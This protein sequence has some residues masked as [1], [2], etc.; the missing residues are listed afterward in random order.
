MPFAGS[1]VVGFRAS[2]FGYRVQ[3]VLLAAAAKSQCICINRVYG[4][5]IHSID[6]DPYSVPGSPRL[7]QEPLCATSQPFPPNA[8]T[9]MPGAPANT[10]HASR[11]RPCQRL[12]FRGQRS[13]PCTQSRPP[14]GPETFRE[15]ARPAPTRQSI[16][17]TLWI[18]A[19]SSSTSGAVKSGGPVFAYARS[20]SSEDAER[21]FG[22]KA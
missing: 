6:L 17:H 12:L 22:F 21:L 1:T 8:K 11:I 10:L 7:L 13:T 2:G 9:T 4:E 19:S 20:F 18:L 3:S 15:N 14:T 5:E 16:I